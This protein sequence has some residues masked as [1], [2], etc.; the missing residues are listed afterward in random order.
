MT[1][2]EGQSLALSRK[3][4]TKVKCL[5]FAREF[6]ESKVASGWLEYKETTDNRHPRWSSYISMRIEKKE[7][8]IVHVIF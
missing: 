8:Y 4:S 5:L 1:R 7:A 6:A 3:W 2:K